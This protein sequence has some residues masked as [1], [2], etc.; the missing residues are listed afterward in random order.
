VVLSFSM[1]TV[2]RTT[3]LYQSASKS[4]H[5]LTPLAM[6]CARKLHFLML[7]ASRSGRERVGAVTLSGDEVPPGPVSLMRQVLSLT[8]HLFGAPK[9]RDL[10]HGGP[11]ELLRILRDG[12]PRT[13]AELGWITGL[14]RAATSSRLEALLELG[15]VVPVSDAASTGGR[16][17]AR[18]ALNPGARLAAAADIGATHATVALTDLSEG[19]SWKPPNDF[20][21][22]A[23][24]KLFWTG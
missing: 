14:G 24:P 21:Y 19:F 12:R 9:R 8:I 7:W 3:C 6:E 22:R 20:R 16:P 5:R 18:L 11:G 1:P 10:N 17:S 15:L 2:T 23:D 4:L 13:R